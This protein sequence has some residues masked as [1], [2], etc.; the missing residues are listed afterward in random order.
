MLLDNS[1][2]C[3]M[4]STFTLLCNTLSTHVQI[5]EFTPFWSQIICRSFI[6]LIPFWWTLDSPVS[7]V[8]VVMWN[9]IVYMSKSRV[10]PTCCTVLIPLI[11]EFPHWMNEFRFYSSKN[12]FSSII[13]LCLTCAVK[14]ASSVQLNLRYIELSPLL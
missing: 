9:C 11:E 5:F 3:W 7:F 2:C 13:Q 14:C 12:C 4:N 10:C 8:R 6:F 1:I